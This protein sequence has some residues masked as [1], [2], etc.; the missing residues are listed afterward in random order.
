MIG[1]RGDHITKEIAKK[2]TFYE[3]ALLR[4]LAKMDPQGICVDVGAHIG[5]HT[6]A[7]ATY[8]GCT[9]V[10]AFEPNP[11]TFPYLHFNASSL[12]RQGR[13][14]VNHWGIHDTWSCGHSTDA[15]ENSGMARL[16]PG[17]DVP[18][19]ALDDVLEPGVGLIKIDTEGLELAVL[20]SATATI[21]RDRPIVV[22][23][24]FDGACRAALWEFLKPMGYYELA[25][26]NAT[27]TYVFEHR[28]RRAEI[29]SEW[30]ETSS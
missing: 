29:P 9:R 30:E 27:P 26:F 7:F 10:I 16:L 20:R 15:A 22:A 12:V 6:L 11:V 5:N 3:A 19:A 1:P 17:G 24:A 8:P 13:A 23:E 14:T 21:A 2:G 18:V 4:F 28:V 25:C